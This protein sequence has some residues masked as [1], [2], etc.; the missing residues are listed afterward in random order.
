MSFSSSEIAKNSGVMTIES[1]IF[2]IFSG[3]NDDVS[4]VAILRR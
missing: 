3:G 1:I 4:V 2:S